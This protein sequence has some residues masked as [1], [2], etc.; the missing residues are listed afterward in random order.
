MFIGNSSTVAST[1][2]GN[3][4]AIAIS[5]ET[6]TVSA[7]KMNDDY[8]GD[9]RFTGLNYFTKDQIQTDHEIPYGQAVNVD[10]VLEI[11]HFNIAYPKLSE[12]PLDKRPFILFIHG[13]G[14][15]KEDEVRK[16]KMDSELRL[17]SKQGFVAASIDY[18]LGRRKT[19]QCM[20]ADSF[21]S[22]VYRAVQDTKAALRYFVQN[23]ETYGID[24][25]S[26]FIGGRSAGGVTGLHTAFMSQEDIDNVS[27]VWRHNL[28]LLDNSTND[29]D[30][31]YTLKGVVA[32]WTVLY[33]LS[34]WKLACHF[35]SW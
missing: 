28:G 35:L 24:T 23:A 6:V 21:F 1:L 26:M 17:L 9:D 16:Y 27:T 34:K 3:S 2:L 8:C 25:N 30:V 10:G 5:P 18:R 4:V 19:A 33:R 31:S 22:A 32:M 11:L 13:G 29:I 20:A 14:Y 7:I 12:D 15:S